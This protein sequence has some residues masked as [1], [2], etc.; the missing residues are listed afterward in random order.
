MESSLFQHG[1]RI[2]TSK[3][4]VCNGGDPVSREQGYGTKACEHYED[5]RTHRLA[6]ASA[7]AWKTRFRFS[8]R[9]SCNFRGWMLLAWLS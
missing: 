6:A 5:S 8:S 9:A 2:L 1:G 3:T 4:I 7:I